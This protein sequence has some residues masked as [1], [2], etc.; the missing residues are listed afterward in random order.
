M[1]APFVP[2]VSI[3]IPAFD[4][5]VGI[6][7]A[8]RSLAA[9][10]YPELEVIVVDDGSTHGTAV[11]VERL[12]LEGVQVVRQPNLGKPA[13]L[14]HGIAVARNDVLVLVDADTVFEPETLRLLVQPFREPGVGAVSGNTK[15]GNRRALLGRWQHIE[16]VMGFNLDRR[17]YDVLPCMPTVPGAIGAFRRQALAQMGGISDATLAEDTDATIA[18]GRAGWRIVY[19]EE[20]RAWT[21]A[22]SSLGA[23]WRQRYGWCYGTLQ[24]IWKHRAAAWRN[25][26]ERI[27]RRPPIPRPRPDR[28][29]AARSPDRPLLDLRPPARLVRVP[30]RPRIAMAAR[31][32]AV[33]AARLPPAH[34]PGRGRVGAVGAPRNPPTL[35]AQRPH[36][37]GR[38]RALTRARSR[39]PKDA[40][41]SER[42]AARLRPDAQSMRTSADPDPRQ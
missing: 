8:I 1:E 11:L 19:V 27:G 28:P 38:G 15:V 4:E 17:L 42:V 30:A 13:A 2:P 5:A 35:A 23:L 3:V 18:L 16:Y 25:G 37:R 22:P 20:A 31:G 39:L 21:E 12:G 36:R 41:V 10:E 26:E 29:A 34:V 24:S 32:D 40:G 14:N 9:S 6:E 33:P 7:R